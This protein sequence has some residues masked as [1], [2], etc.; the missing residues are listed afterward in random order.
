MRNNIFGFIAFFCIFSCTVK[1]SQTPK[2]E[3]SQYSMTGEWIFEEDD[4]GPYIFTFTDKECTTLFLGDDKVK[5][6]NYE[7]EGEK[8]FIT[9]KD[10]MLHEWDYEF[11]DEDTLK[12]N[13]ETDQRYFTGRRVKNDVTTLNGVYRLVNGVGFIFSFEFIDSSNV[14][15]KSSPVHGGFMVG[16]ST[17][18]ID[19]SSVLL[20][21]GVLR[22]NLEIVGDT[23]LLIRIP[24]DI[25]AVFEKE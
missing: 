4:G 15:I 7:I 13:I 12:I 17:Y 6:A 8:I 1:E 10:G 22:R 2:A 25:I 16:D 14:K 24:D 20:S 11:Q 21:S 9:T 19:G 23:I 18:E 5:T 3:Q